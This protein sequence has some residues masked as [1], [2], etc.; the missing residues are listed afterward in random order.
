MNMKIKYAISALTIG[1]AAPAF[2]QDGQPAQ[3]VAV[4]LD[5]NHDHELS[6]S[7]IRNAAKSLLKLDK[8]R[9]KAISM[10][11][12]KPEQQGGS[13][14]PQPP[15]SDLMD[16]IDLDG[17]GDLSSD[18]LEAASTSLA[19][20]DADG[21]GKIDETEATSLLATPN[22]SGIDPDQGGVERQGP[23]GPGGPPPGGPRR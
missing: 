12:L 16:A 21:N 17:S 4:S 3:I 23:R 7:E 22:N 8:D 11:E 6:R 1:L 18:E 5:K 13:Q 14:T 9:D 2:A 20:L 19:T 10:E 15:A